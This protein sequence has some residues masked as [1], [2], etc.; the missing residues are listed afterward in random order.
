MIHQRK[1]CFVALLGVAGVGT[2]YAGPPLDRPS[3]PPYCVDGVCRPNALTYGW[4]QTRWRRWPTV[5]LEPTP[6][7]AKPSGELVPELPPVDRPRKEDEDRAAPP[8]TKAAERAREEEEQD[9]SVPTPGGEVPGGVPFVPPAGGFQP[10][11]SGEGERAPTLEMPWERQE[12]TTP[13]APT[14]GPTGDLDPPPTP[15]F[16]GPSLAN[17]APGVRR[18]EVARPGR[19][20]PRATTRESSDDPPPAYPLAQMLR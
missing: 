18:P 20:W 1:I 8:P 9:S 13:S 15:T 19:S 7:E 16:S 14:T 6:A 5:A 3:P 12:P 10:R 11:P 2:G 17:G 4:Y